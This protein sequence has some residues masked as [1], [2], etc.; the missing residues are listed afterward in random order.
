[1]RISRSAHVRFESI[2]TS[3]VH[4]RDVDVDV[5]AAVDFAERC[6]RIH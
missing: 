3:I 2:A 6:P 5:A 4:A 1:M